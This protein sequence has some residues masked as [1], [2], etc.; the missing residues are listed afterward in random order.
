MASYASQEKLM[1]YACRRCADL[2]RSFSWYSVG[3]GPDDVPCPWCQKELADRLYMLI[4]MMFKQNENNETDRDHSLS[5]HYL[6][7][8]KIYHRINS[9]RGDSESY[10]A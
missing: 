7:A 10:P 8:I 5:D 9:N 3:D 6:E 1:H 4:E 2:N